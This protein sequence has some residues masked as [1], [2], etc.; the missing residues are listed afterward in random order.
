MTP[1]KPSDRVLMNHIS[2][3]VRYEFDPAFLRDLRKKPSRD[4]TVA[5][6][7]GYLLDSDPP[8]PAGKGW[9][10]SDT[11]YILLGAIIEKITHHKLYAEIARSHRGA[12]AR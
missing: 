10:Y 11:N 12:T 7:L 8:F 3:V 9:T 6:R 2:G 5:D 1:L 4:W